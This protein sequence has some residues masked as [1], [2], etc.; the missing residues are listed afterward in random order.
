[1]QGTIKSASS[2]GVMCEKGLDC[3]M[4]MHNEIKK[5]SGTRVT[6]AEAMINERPF[7][8]KDAQRKSARKKSHSFVA[9][10]ISGWI[11]WLKNAVIKCKR[12]SFKQVLF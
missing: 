3:G 11:I 8:R 4:I 2:S 9:N 5:V 12:K 1:M 10:T 6:D 7:P